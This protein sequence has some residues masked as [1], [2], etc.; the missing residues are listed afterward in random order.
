[1]YNF[2]MF[3]LAP[4]EPVDY[5]VIGHIT[6]DLTPGG[7]VIGGTAT[8]SALTARAMGLRVGI[9]TAYNTEEMG[10]LPELNGIAVVAIPS[11]T[12]TT[13]ENI[14]IPHGR[15]QYLHSRASMLNVSQIPETW[16]RTPIV[17]LGPIANEIEP[18]IARVFSDSFVGLTPQGWLRE[19]GDDG[20]VHLGEW[21]EASYVLQKANAC[22]ISI[23]D[24]H[25]DESRIE[26]L[27]S[28]IR[29][30]VVTEGPDGC[31]VYW[32]GD[33]RR[34][35]SPPSVEVDPTGAG[36]IFA[37]AFFCRLTT[38]RDPWEAARFA[39]Q[40]AATSVSR[41]YLSGV[42]TP[43]EIQAAE[44]DVIRGT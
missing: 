39:N 27:V 19:W 10:L 29:V 14:T 34:F 8:Y 41:R 5:L 15:I 18:G 36:D 7:S 32:N 35:K 4:I 1:M 3:S 24:V 38:T 25:S 9:L 13:F 28:S 20:L 16:R 21:P 23:H 31:R 17:H 12:T 37:T 40:I 30:L 26:E 2:T 22:V 6:K 42:P 44:I 33:L 43:E 11:E